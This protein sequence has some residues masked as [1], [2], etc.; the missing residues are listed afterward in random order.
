MDWTSQTQHCWYVPC[1]HSP[2]LL[3][4]LRALEPSLHCCCIVALAATAAPA[5]VKSSATET[6]S[7][8]LAQYSSQHIHFRNF[9][10]Q[11]MA[12]ESH[13]LNCAFAAIRAAGRRLA[14]ESRHMGTASSR[15]AVLST[16]RSKPCV[17]HD[18]QDVPSC[19]LQRHQHAAPSCG[20]RLSF[21]YTWSYSVFVTLEY[22]VFATPAL[23][24]HKT[25]TPCM[26]SGL[27]WCDT[28]AD[29]MVKPRLI[30]VL[31]ELVHA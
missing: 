17:L 5:T 7:T 26:N 15:A 13:Y 23:A 22:A 3:P 8:S 2:C 20:C 31:G 28:Q 9:T 10:T 27:S 6:K 25:C 29:S 14:R 11:A 19:G 16:F 4:A 30:V 21:L 24:H 18:S 1:S 12:C